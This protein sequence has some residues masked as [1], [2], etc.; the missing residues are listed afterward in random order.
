MRARARPSC[1]RGC[2]GR[3]RWQI[4]TRWRERAITLKLGRIAVGLGSL[5]GFPRRPCLRAEGE[6]PGAA[7]FRGKT[8]LLLRW[9]GSRATHVC[10]RACRSTA[11]S[12]SCWARSR[13]GCPTCSRSAHC[14]RSA[15]SPRGCL[16]GGSPA[17]FCAGCGRGGLPTSAS[18]SAR[19]SPPPPV[20]AGPSAGSTRRRCPG[21]SS[22]RSLSLAVQARLAVL[23]GDIVVDQR[24][25][26]RR[27]AVGRIRP[28]GNQTGIRLP[29]PKVGAASFA[30]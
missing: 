25:A 1:W 20:D 22:R 15:D 10:H 21:W 4:A 23:G 19:T 18:G 17:C 3:P 16:P 7:L 6:H 11:C 26:V 13:R 8:R 14:R 24:S 12:C 9:R 5:R 2:V 30:E 28:T 29:P 27:L